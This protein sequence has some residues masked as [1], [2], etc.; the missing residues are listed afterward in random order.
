MASIAATERNGSKSNAS[1][2]HVQSSKEAMTTEGTYAAHNYHPLPIVFA[3]A[4]GVSVWDPVWP[5][6][7]LH[8]CHTML[9]RFGR[10]VMN[11]WTS[12]LHTA[13]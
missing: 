3:R 12:C 5:V 2:Y 6:Q 10:R 11:I 13:L 1:R 4:Q 7:Y 8:Y 9:T